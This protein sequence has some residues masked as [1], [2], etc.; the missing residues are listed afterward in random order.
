MKRL[1]RFLIVLAIVCSTFMAKAQND[2]IAFTLMPHIPYNNYLNPGI[3]VPYNGMFG[4]GISNFNMSI[5]NSSVKYT[6]IYKINGNGEEVID[7]KKFVNSLQDQDNYFNIDFSMDLLNVGFRYKKLFFNIDYRMR[8]NMEFKFSKDF[9]GFFVLGNGNYLGGNT[10]DFNIGI[11]A[12]AFTEFGV[13][14][15]YDVND[16][17]T[18]GIRPKLLTGI[19]NV[20]VTNENT[21]IMTDPNTYSITADVDLNIKAASILDTDIKRIKDV[22]DMLSSD[23]TKGINLNENKG[24]G[25]DLGA[26]YKINEKWGVAAGVYDLGY[27]KW[28]NSKVKKVSKSNV[29]INDELFDSYKEIKNMK[30]DYSSMLNNVVDEVWGNDSLEDGKDYKTMLKTRIM[31]QGYYEINPMVRFTAIGQLYSALGGMK[32][33]MTLAYSGTF[34]NHLDVSVSYT[35]SKYS[36]NALGLGLGVHAGAFNLFMVADNVLS[37][38]KVAKPTVEF[39]TAY[40]SAGFRAG[41]VFTF[42]KYQGPKWEKKVKK[43]ETEMEVQKQEVDTEAIDKAQEEYKKQQQAQ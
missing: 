9:V 38:T 30:L 1:Y 39:A 20:S 7:G 23:K 11:S 34:W 4:L 14:V 40:K 2:G 41:I 13:G 33:A 37:M 22:T 27:I 5:Y 16:K 3:R 19:A 42:G 32:P 18:V 35:L 17:L 31:L 8:A 29:T 15:Q 25:V 43:N 10:C 24:F 36:G 21:K 6:N 12:T 26:S 28:R